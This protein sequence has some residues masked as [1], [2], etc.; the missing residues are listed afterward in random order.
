MATEG[1][2]PEQVAEWM[3]A[4]HRALVKLNKV[5]QHHLAAADELGTPK[6]LEGLRIGFERLRAHLSRHFAAQEAG[7]YLNLV[8][9]QRPTLSPQVEQ[10]RRAHDEILKLAD[11]I[12]RDLAQTSGDERLVAADLGARVQRFIE[13]VRQHERD[14][15]TLTLLALNQDLGGMD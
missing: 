7:G 9:E 10:L 1:M 14:E 11:W 13:L 6:W 8:T 15:N 3:R 5:L 4:E 2:T 12:M